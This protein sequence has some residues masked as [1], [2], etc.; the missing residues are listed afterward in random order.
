LFHLVLESHDG[1]AFV[2]SPKRSASP[3]V[4]FD[5]AVVDSLKRLTSTGR[6]EKRTWRKPTFETG[7]FAL[8]RAEQIDLRI[9]KD[10]PLSKYRREIARDAFGD[11]GMLL[12][13]A[14]EFL[15]WQF[16]ARHV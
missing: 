6:L 16:Q 14:V 8:E 10:K 12:A 1:R 11:P 2:P 9:G 3:Q 4:T 13:E 5:T 7:H 15:D